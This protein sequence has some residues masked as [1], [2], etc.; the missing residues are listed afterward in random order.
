MLLNRC[1]VQDVPVAEKG[2]VD[3]PVFYSDALLELLDRVQPAQ[4]SSRLCR[5]TPLAR[6]LLQ[7]YCLCETS[8]I[9]R[10]L[11]TLSMRNSRRTVRSVF[12]TSSSS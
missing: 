5:E 4:A 8:S 7:P 11:T 1:I 3:D 2:W 10:A 6:E 9:V 12:C